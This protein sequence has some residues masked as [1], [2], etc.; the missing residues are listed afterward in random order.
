MCQKAKKVFQKKE[1]ERNK[2]SS[3]KAFRNERCVDYLGRCSV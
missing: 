2:G 3:H 1:W